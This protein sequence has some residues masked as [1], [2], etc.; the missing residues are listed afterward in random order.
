MVRLSLSVLTHHAGV[1][2]AWS[3]GADRASHDADV[4]MAFLLLPSRC[5]MSR[6]IALPD[7]VDMPMVAGIDAAR[8]NAPNA[9]LETILALGSPAPLHG[10]WQPSCASQ[11]DRSDARS[12]RYLLNGQFA[13]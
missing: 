1:S 12:G 8:Q 6:Q 10:G 7:L 11:A 9:H 2:V 3:D 5:R 4:S 13:G